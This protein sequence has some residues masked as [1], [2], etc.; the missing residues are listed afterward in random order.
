[1]VD[2]SIDTIYLNDGMVQATLM[3]HD[4]NGDI[5]IRQMNFPTWEMARK[6]AERWTVNADQISAEYDAEMAR[7]K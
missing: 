7:A 3:R 1:M 6:A 2:Y 5:P 4:E